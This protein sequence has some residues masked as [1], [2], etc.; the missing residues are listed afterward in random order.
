[1]L[2][3]GYWLAI[4][5]GVALSEHFVFKRGFAG[6]VP[7]HY[8]DPSKL[9]PG[10]AACTAF[11]FGVMGAILGMAQIWFTGPIGKLCGAAFGGDVGFELAFCFATIS[12]LVLRT[13]E[14][15]YFKR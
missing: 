5:E 15:S 9:P 7:E 13:I 3:I 8:T 11:A 2:V 4:Y 1:M 10:Y 14:K 6:Y 12:Y